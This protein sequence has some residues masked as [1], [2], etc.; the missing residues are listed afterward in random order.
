MKSRRILAL[1]L[2]ILLLVGAG[3]AIYYF[4]GSAEFSESETA[5]APGK[6]SPSKTYAD[7]PPEEVVERAWAFYESRPEFQRPRPPSDV[8]AGLPDTRAATCGSC[9]VE[10][11][12]EWQLSTHRRA[13]LDD[14]QFMAELE[15]SRGE[16]QANDTLPDDEAHQQ[17]DVG[18]MCVNCHTPS[19]E[20]L[21]ELVVGLKD[22]ELNRPIY[23]K[24]PT[25]DAEFQ[26]E[27]ISCATCHVRDG[28]VYGPFGDTDAPHATAKDPK[29]LTPESCTDCHNAQAVF[30][31]QN[32]G[33]FFTTGDEW[34]TSEYPETEQ[35]CQSCH[36]PHVERKLAAGFDRP[37]RMT[38]RHWF[39]GSLIP[40]KAEYADALAPLQEIYGSAVNIELRVALKGA[41]DEDAKPAGEPDPEFSAD[42]TRCAPEQPCLRLLVRLSNQN[43]GHKFPTGDPER[44]ADFHVTATNAQGD[45]LARASERIAS[46]YQW[47]PTIEKLTDNRILP[48]AN[49]DI[50]LEIPLDAD[51]E[52]EASGPITVEVN[53]HKYRMYKEAFEHHDLEDEYVR[54]RK[55]HTSKWSVTPNAAATSVALITL[56]DDAGT[57]D[58]LA[59]EPSP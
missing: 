25:F 6:G 55:F 37:P 46:R 7:I 13:W 39:G 38:R 29:L 32:L 41:S 12:E 16:A 59:A 15:K 54:G 11:Y 20:Q 34:A 33:C 23:A 30:P 17:D 26:E 4:G 52:G 45:V 22:G 21:P 42:S 36:M 18:W 51:S 49:H 27:A 35:S 31:A 28:V 43:A 1:I 19:I 53:A 57:R 48:G 5:S 50:R 8:P 9:H 56:T 40:K 3:F 44:H 58:T 14:A 10:I 47:W 24:N 2:A